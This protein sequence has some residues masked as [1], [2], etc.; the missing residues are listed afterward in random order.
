V[1]SERAS[2]TA[3]RLEPI[4]LSAVATRGLAAKRA[5]A[6]SADIKNAKARIANVTNA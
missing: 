5:S 2:I 6:S 1:S 3:K 4:A